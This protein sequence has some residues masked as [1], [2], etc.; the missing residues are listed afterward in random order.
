MVAPDDL[1]PLAPGDELHAPD[2]AF[3]VLGL[4]HRLRDPSPGHA[5]STGGVALLAETADPSA[6]R[7]V[8]RVFPA[9]VG[10]RPGA[11]LASAWPPVVEGDVHDRGPV[12]WIPA[13][14][15]HEALLLPR[16]RGWLS[17][18][19]A[20]QV[21]AAPATSAYRA[22]P[23]RVGTDLRDLAPPRPFVALACVVGATLSTILRAAAARS[24]PLG[25]GFALALG[26]RVAGALAALESRPVDAPDGPRAAW[27]GRLDARHVFVGAD[28]RCLLLPPLLRVNVVTSGGLFRVADF[29]GF[30][31]VDDP[32]P[33][34]MWSPP[35]A[36]DAAADRWALG[37]LLWEIATGR[38]PTVDAVEPPRPSSVDPQ[39][40]PALDRCVAGLLA[41]DEGR[42]FASAAAASA[43]LAEALRGFEGPCDEAALAAVVRVL[44]R[45]ADDAFAL[46]GDGR[47][48]TGEV[49]AQR[50]IETS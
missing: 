20:P 50:F 29:P 46:A 23:V 31:D 5:H 24:L 44:G 35:W 25:S 27:H 6:T 3:R 39:V 28:G 12:D 33:S 9:R 37:W 41:R 21:A 30:G 22:A 16:W 49:A 11:H 36:R 1:P 14:P 34:R 8:L 18:H 26:A 19:G 45:D 17:A 38:A 47:D 4:I 2:V 10:A 13:G 48:G 15:A 7:V 42:A 43:A 32:R 40:P